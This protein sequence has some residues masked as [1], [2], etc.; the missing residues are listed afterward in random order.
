MRVAAGG[1]GEV[2]IVRASHDKT[3]EPSINRAVD[4]RAN[5]FTVPELPATYVHRS[6]LDGAFAGLSQRRLTIVT[7]AIGAGKTTLLASFAH[8][9]PRGSVAWCTLDER[10]S[11][12]E[13]LAA[14]ILGAVLAAKAHGEMGEIATVRSTSPDPL[15][16]AMDLAAHGAHLVLVLDDVERLTTRAARAALQRLVQIA[17]PNLSTVLVTR[18]DPDFHP[19]RFRGEQPGSLRAGELAFTVDETRALFER[20]DID[21]TDDDVETLTAWTEGSAAALHLAALLL[22]VG[23]REAVLEEAELGERTVIDFLFNGVLA[24]LPPDLRD[25]LVRTSIVDAINAD[26][27]ADL[28]PGADVA[29]LLDAATEQQLLLASARSDVGGE[30]WWYHHSLTADLLRATLRHEYTSELAALHS[31]A[32][33]WFE[34]AGDREDATFH[35]AAAGEWDFVARA[36]V[37]AW[38]EASLGCVHM[39][40]RLAAYQLPIDVS[41][42]G[43][44]YTLAH[45]IRAFEFGD[46]RPATLGDHSISLYTEPRDRLVAALLTLSIACE[47]EDTADA[48]E[49]AADVVLTAATEGCISLQEHDQVA[50]LVLFARAQARIRVGDLGS[51]RD[52]LECALESTPSGEEAAT[53]TATA[54][55]A[56]TESLRGLLRQATAH[57]DEIGEIGVDPS[58]PRIAGLCS[59]TLAITRY[60]ADDLAGARAAVA[61]AREHLR[62][63]VFRDVV[64]AAVG[65]GVARAD[66]DREATKRQLAHVT[67]AGCRPLVAILADT[68]GFAEL[69][70]HSTGSSASHPY[71]ATFAH[72][73]AAADAAAR[74]ETEAARAET[75]RALA[76]I[77]RHGYRRAFVDCGL[78]VRDLLLDY[79]GAA[80]PYRMLA[81]QLLERIW[82]ENELTASALVE[83]LTERELTV[84]R[85]LPT[86]MSNSEIA[87]EMYFSV[88]T[89]KTH[90]KS[91]YRKLEVTRRREAV[92]RARDLSLI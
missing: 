43:S 24:A 29:P 35:A 30:R 67:N 59:L 28:V 56:V 63:G 88:N 74:R 38:L 14:S 10:D 6:R 89:V 65:A 91:I 68:L 72:L 21:V 51:A 12:P 42:A 80:R 3:Y 4:A 47:G 82:I 32:A 90:L 18:R 37:D 1:G 22:R 75:R 76:I 57:I 62:G 23:G 17:P 71:V 79:V 39:P 27:A 15:E 9:Q 66:N 84:L 2:T 77:D 58:L 20:F 69:A 86:M 92:D 7:G 87:G 34:S 48:I 33:G 19:R 5:A 31:R 13:V 50:L 25:F 45:A 64:L 49:A 26:L 41:E 46:N 16:Q 61:D 54:M 40:P 44:S 11:Q 81:T 53:A 60:H 52:L 83:R 73:A 8:A 55:L 36:V 85:Y 78:P 70:P